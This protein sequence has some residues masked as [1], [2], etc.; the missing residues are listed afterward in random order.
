MYHISSLDELLGTKAD[1]LEISKVFRKEIKTYTDTLRESFEEVGGKQFLFKHTKQI[2]SFITYMYKFSTI[3]IFE[4]YLPMTSH[5]PITLCALGSYGREQ[6]C[7]YSDI[8]LMIVYKDIPGYNANTIIE[9]MLYMMW[10]SGL[11][12]G[13]RVHELGDLFTAAHED[14]TIKTAM[15]ESRFICGSKTLWFEVEN[16]LTRIKKHE[17]DTFIESKMDEYNKRLQR[18]PLTMEPDIKDGFGGIRDSNTLFWIANVLYSINSLKELSGRLFSEEEYREF[19]IA[20]EFVFRVRSAL[21]LSAGR[22][23]DKLILELLPGIA[24]MLGFDGNPKKAQMRCASKT[25]EACETIHRFSQIQI[26]RLLKSRRYDSKNIRLLKKAFIPSRRFFLM[27]STLCCSFN[28][29]TMTLNEI[30]NLLLSLPD[31]PIQFDIRVKSVFAKTQADESPHQDLQKKFYQ[32]MYRKHV[33]ELLMVLLETNLLTYLYPP[34]KKVRLLPQFD[35]YHQQPVD[36]HTISCFRYLENI[37]NPFI[38]K[39]YEGLNSELR[40]LLKLVLFFHDLG[41]GRMVDH[42]IVGERMFRHF[43]HQIELERELIERGALLVLYHTLM[44]GVAQ[45][46]DIYDEKTLLTFVSYVKDKTNL[47]LLYVLTYADVSGVG[48]GILTKFIEKL[49]Y[50][51]YHNALP[52]LGREELLNETS[53]RIKKEESLKKMPGYANLPKVLQ[54]KISGIPTNAFFI[55]LK[56][57]EILRIAQQSHETREYDYNIHNDNYLSIEIIRRI[58]LNLGYFLGKLSSMSVSAMDIFK[59]YDNAKYF[60]VEFNDRAHEE[61]IPL[62]EEL[63]HNSFDMRQ[64]VKIPTPPIKPDEVSIDSEHSKTLAEIRINTQDSKGL[65]AFITQVFDELG[66]EIVSSKSHT[67][68]RRVRDLFLI[69]KNESFWNNQ[70]SLIAKLTNTGS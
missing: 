35:G 70:N 52:A 54:K 68:K 20:L 13:H 26:G 51:L 37:Q 64:S 65:L 60:R 53:R 49:L 44:S 11:K 48:K 69:E 1:S 46:E 6:L 10:D 3:D 7:V 43:A 39:L 27:D 62:I 34:L 66:I 29:K 59:L 55:K 8:D 22:K 40:A 19:R 17:P 4:N 16:E 36:Y 25:L 14:P 67:F 63:I 24:E 5:I 57:E 21:H 33:Y 50:E 61:D 12:L 32:L 9:K 41:K 2:D 31:E 28:K 15:L 23:Q 30:L 58:P 45:R 42:H 38:R 18:Y 47:D 56:R